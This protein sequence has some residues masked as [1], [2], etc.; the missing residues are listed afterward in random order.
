MT[1]PLTSRVLRGAFVAGTVLAASTS[2]ALATVASPNQKLLDL[3]AEGKTETDLGRYDVAIRALS[4]IV[5]APDATPALRNEALVRLGVARRGAD[6]FEGA[7]KAFER[8]STASSLDRETKAL[9]VQALGGALPG[10]E[11]WA[12]IWPRVSFAVDRTDPHRPTMAISWPD[13]V[14]AKVYR[15][16]PLTL[17]QE[18]DIQG[19]FRL[20]ADASGLNVV[21]YPGVHGRYAAHIENEPW[22]RVLDFVLSANGY[23]YQWEDNVLQ[24][25]RPQQLPR[26]RP[27]SGQRIDVDWGTNGRAP[28]RD[29]REGLAELAAIGGQTVVLDPAVEGSVVIKL[30][31]VRCDQAFDVIVHVNGL[32]WRRE[33]GTWKVFPRE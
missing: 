11:R 9:L 27:F 23:A 30:N 21:V 10:T 3:M 4:T 7:F 25:A 2:P 26:P 13:V 18:G 19:L 20:I 22:D 24:V 32:D 12:Q 33:R 1:S 16:K 17:R 29:L 15:G 8:A 14:Q 6:D 5:D 31:Q 28:G